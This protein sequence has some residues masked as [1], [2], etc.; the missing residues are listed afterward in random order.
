MHQVCIRTLL[1]FTLP[2]LPTVERSAHQITLRDE[3]RLLS[4]GLGNSHSRLAHREGRAVGAFG[5]V[6]RQVL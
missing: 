5:E 2:L 3:A 1:E 6:H 4:S